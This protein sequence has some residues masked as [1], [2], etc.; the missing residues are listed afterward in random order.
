MIVRDA[1]VNQLTP[2]LHP[3]SLNLGVLHLG[4]ESAG[5]MHFGFEFALFALMPQDTHNAHISYVQI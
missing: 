1:T 2:T 3:R 4:L 5:V